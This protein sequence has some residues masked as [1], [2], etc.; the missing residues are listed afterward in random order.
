MLALA[1]GNCQ[2]FTHMFVVAV[3]LA[4]RKDKK[5]GSGLNLVYLT[6]PVQV[7][8]KL[9]LPEVFEQRISN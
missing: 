8:K 1:L 2:G 7:C 3:G 5:I 9:L 4:V 6:P